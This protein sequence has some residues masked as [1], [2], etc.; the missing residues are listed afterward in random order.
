MSSVEALHRAEVTSGE[1]FEFGK[2]WS[3]FLSTL[4]DDR[5]NLAERSLVSFLGAERLDGKTFLDIGSGSGLFSLCARR[6]GAKVFSFDYDPHSVACTRELRRRYFPE[7]Q[8]WR[9]DSGSVLDESYLSTLGT[10]DIVY[11]WG[12]LH[13]TGSMWQALNNVKPLVKVGGQLFI[14]IYND[15]GAATDDWAAIKKDYN[16]R[17]QLGALMLALGVIWREE[18]KSLRNHWKNRTIGEWLR[19]WTEYDKI[20]T[21]GMSRWHDWIDWIGG[22]PYERATVEQIVDVYGDDGFRLEKLADRSGEYGCNEFVFRREGEAGVVVDQRLPGGKT[23]A[24]RFGRR[25]TQPFSIEGDHLLA[26]LHMDPL[27]QS[28]AFLI[29]DHAI[30]EPAVFVGEDRVIVGRS[31]DGIEA[32]G[33]RRPILVTGAVHSLERPYAHQRGHMYEKTVTQFLDLSDHSGGGERR[34]RLFVLENGVQ[35]PDPH[36][37][38]DDIDHH[39]RGRFSHWGNSVYFSASD[40]SDPNQN[41]KTYQLFVADED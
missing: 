19:T 18:K 34:S 29:T 9:V 27:K 36:S 11:S 21:R 14:A 13:H 16:S 40:N 17:S 5:I 37:L 3:R 24:R 8:D 4:N 35:L 26:R 15:M 2:N 23:L 25:L 20:S 28:R 1:R 33:K 39:G 38:H 6:L 31:A 7:D 30:V 10:F 22:Y 41:G 12:V 32:V